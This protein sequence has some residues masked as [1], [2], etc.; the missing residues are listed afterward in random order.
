MAKAALR[1]QTFWRCVSQQRKYLIA[2]GIIEARDNSRATRNRAAFKIQKVSKTFLAKIHARKELAMARRAK[3]EA[4]EAR[5][6]AVKV[7]ATD[8][9][10]RVM[11]VLSNREEQLALPSHADNHCTFFQSRLKTSSIS[12]VV[13]TL[14]TH[15]HRTNMKPR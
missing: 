1:L 14:T 3:E 15:S 8:V 4:F 11:I 5:L 10:S 9:F 12:I 2:R 13:L 6:Q 7:R